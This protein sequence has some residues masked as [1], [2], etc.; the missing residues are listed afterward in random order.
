MII[1]KINKTDIRIIKT[2]KWKIEIQIGKGIINMRIGIII[3]N[4]GRAG[5]IDNYMIK[6]RN[7]E[8]I[9]IVININRKK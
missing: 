8:T 1:M 6:I 2:L 4:R 3:N 7:I 9:K 5:T